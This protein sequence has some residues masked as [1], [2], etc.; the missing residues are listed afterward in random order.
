LVITWSLKCLKDIGWNYSLDHHSFNY[1]NAANQ[2]PTEA[3]YTWKQQ[4]VAAFSEKTG[5]NP[6]WST[7]CLEETE[8][9]FIR[10]AAAF[11]KFKTLDQL[12]Q[13]PFSLNSSCKW[14]LCFVN[15]PE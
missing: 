5:M 8:W 13:K 10:A 14:W 15:H 4:I 9:D 3:Y 12:P 1:F 11:H 2:I 7:K 6:I